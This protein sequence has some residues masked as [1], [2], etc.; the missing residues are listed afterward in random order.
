M[1][2]N[3]VLFISYPVMLY[4]IVDDFALASVKNKKLLFSNEYFAVLE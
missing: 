2:L 1:K 3:A 4:K